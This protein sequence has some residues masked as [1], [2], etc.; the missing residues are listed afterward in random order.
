MPM[1]Q[2]GNS[3]PIR[4]A[5]TVRLSENAPPPFSCRGEHGQSRFDTALPTTK[6]VSRESTMISP[7]PSDQF[8]RSLQSSRQ[9]ISF[10]MRLSAAHPNPTRAEG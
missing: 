2:E 5:S 1:L 9:P 10:T 3:A 6:G 4:A 8:T 7:L